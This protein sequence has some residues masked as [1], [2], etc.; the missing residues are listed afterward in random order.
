MEHRFT[1]LMTAYSISIYQ[2]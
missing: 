2:S 1:V